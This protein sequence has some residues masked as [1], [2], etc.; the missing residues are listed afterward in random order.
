M[1]QP[2]YYIDSRTSAIITRFSHNKF[3]ELGFFSKRLSN[4]WISKYLINATLFGEFQLSTHWIKI[5]ISTLVES[6]QILWYLLNVS[7]APR[8]LQSLSN[9]D[10]QASLWYCLFN[11]LCSYV[12]LIYLL[13]YSFTTYLT[14]TIWYWT[15]EFI[16]YN[17]N[18]LHL[19]NKI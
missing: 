12:H 18:E 9:I 14:R 5:L 6:H 2:C 15:A 13:E 17:E 10:H 16:L 8:A 7:D 19:N 3:S 1:R 11:F 4:T